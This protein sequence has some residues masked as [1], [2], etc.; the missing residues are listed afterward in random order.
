MKKTII[1]ALAVLA[2]SCAKEEKQCDASGVFEATEVI[3]SAKAQGEILSLNVDEGDQVKAGDVLG[4]IDSKKLSIQ[5]EQLKLTQQSASNRQVDVNAQIASLE[6]QVANLKREKARFEG[7][8]R[9][10]AATQKQVDDLGYQISV[11]QKQI[12]ALQ[13]SLSS[14]N[15]SLESQSNAVGQ[16]IN[17]VDEQIGDATIAAP[18]AGTVLQR[19]C[20]PGEYATPGKPLFKIADLGEMTLRA[21]VTADQF[22]NLKL[23]QK[24]TVMID[25]GDKGARTYDGIVSW[26][27]SRAEFT[28]KTIQTKDERANLVYAIKIKVNNDGFI[29]IGM[30]GDVKL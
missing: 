22:N 1:I 17:L 6:Q 21:Y 16:Q 10:N 23:G 24:V 29:K 15:Q 27:A 13:N 19:Y 28:P 7:L 20:E 11:A 25:G 5:K 4:T 2:V 18:L 12:A 8:L 3:V 26:I 30:Y 14:S 9:D